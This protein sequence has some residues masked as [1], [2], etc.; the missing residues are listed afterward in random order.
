MTK[1]VRF[2]SPRV[3]G[4]S[5]VVKMGMAQGATNGHKMTEFGLDRLSV[6]DRIDLMNEIW[7]SVA[8]EP[9]RTHLTLPQPEEL[10][11]RLIEHDAN[12]QEVVSWEEV[13]SQALERFER[14]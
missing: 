10:Q 4:S 2:P 5:V 6:E 8:D 1:H 3:L 14:Q 12:P 7:D 9:G 13:K 11:R